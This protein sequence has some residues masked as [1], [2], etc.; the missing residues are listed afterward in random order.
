MAIKGLDQAIDNLSRVRKNAIPAAS[1]MTI[2]RVATT[3]INQSSSQV[4]RETKV[5]RKLVKERSRLK[6][7][8]VRNPN[9]R[10]IV[11]RGDLPVIKL[12]IRMLGRRPDSILKAG[13]HRYQRAF[14]QRLN[15]GRWHVMQ[16]LPVA[17]KKRYPIEVVKIPMAAP[18]KQAFDEN[19]DRIRRERLPGELASALKQQLRIA[20][21]R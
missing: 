6:R 20:I 1:A 7:A 18:L 21:K 14:I 16:R 10:I 15:N 2:N 19:V 12:G 5:R 8:T 13:Q 17:G 11:N 3:A 9:A 4:A